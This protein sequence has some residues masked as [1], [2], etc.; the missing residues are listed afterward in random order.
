MTLLKEW[1]KQEAAQ[2]SL[3]AYCVFTDATLVAIAEAKPRSTAE[4]ITIHGLG[5][6]KAAKYGPPVL[7]ILELEG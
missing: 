7:A 5:P 1:R 2:L 6:T 4:L 3:P